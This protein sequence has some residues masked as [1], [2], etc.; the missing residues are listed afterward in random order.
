MVIESIDFHIL[1]RLID[2]TRIVCKSG[3]QF[4]RHLL[5]HILVRTYRNNLMKCLHE[6]V[7]HKSFFLLRSGE[8][9]PPDLN[10]VIVAEES[11]RP[12]KLATTIRGK[13]SRFAVAGSFFI[14]NSAPLCCIIA[15]NILKIICRNLSYSRIH[16]GLWAAIV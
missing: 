13:V 6:S 4:D 9:S 1:P 7:Y 15:P 12:K 5:F 2:L 14:S 8:T 11:S 16:A 3:Q 10:K